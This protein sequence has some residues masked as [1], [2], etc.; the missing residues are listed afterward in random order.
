MTKQKQVSWTIFKD[1]V[2]TK[3]LSI[4][5]IEFDSEY[6]L[7][8][9]DGF[10]S[11]ECVLYKQPTDTT[12]LDNFETNYKAKGNKKLSLLNPFSSKEIDGKKLYK[13]VHGE[14]YSVT[15]G[16]NDLVFTITYNWIKINGLEMVGASNGDRVSFYVLDSVTGTYTTIPNYVLNQFG[17]GVNVPKDYYINKSEFDADLYLGMQIKLVYESIDDKNI[18]VNF[19]LTELK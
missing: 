2:D 8:A 19:L 14:S 5:F 15:T 1:F 3:G 17:Y 11:L 13:R 6:S 7:Q 18:G 16:S 9:F 4:Q 10:F 12:D